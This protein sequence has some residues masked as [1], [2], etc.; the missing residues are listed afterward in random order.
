MMTMLLWS[1][2][3]G[4]SHG[5]GERGPCMHD[6]DTHAQHTAGG[7]KK[8]KKEQLSGGSRA[9]C[10]RIHLTSHTILL[11]NNTYCNAP[12]HLHACVARGGREKKKKKNKRLWKDARAYCSA[13]PVGF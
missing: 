13:S 2:D 12:L 6:S 10:R 7:D 11:I 3:D 5:M 4:T 1:V 8:K 9:A